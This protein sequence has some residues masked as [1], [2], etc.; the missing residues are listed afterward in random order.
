MNPIAD[1]ASAHEA[2]RQTRMAKLTDVRGWLNLIGRWPISVGTYTLGALPENDVQLVNAPDHFGQVTLHPD[3]SASF[4][5]AGGKENLVFRGEGNPE[6][7][8]GR[9]IM[10]ISRAGTQLALRIRDKE[11]AALATTEKLPSFPLDPSLRITARLEKL[12]PPMEITIDTIAG[13]PNRA[14]I[15]YVAHFDVVGQAMSMLATYGTPERPQFVFRDMTSLDDTYEKARFLFGEEVTQDSVVLDFNR[16]VN[17]PCAF[18]PFAV[19]PL[20]PREN[21]VSARIEA[22]EKRIM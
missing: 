8:I 19:C 4:L 3:Y 14:S 7:E 21:L 16:A 17:P 6:L 15:S 13:L 5:P 22:G 10:E 18:T 20:P 9:F 12:D 1:F 2:W 11:S